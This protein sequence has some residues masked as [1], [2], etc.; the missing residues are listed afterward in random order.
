MRRAPYSSEFRAPDSV[1]QLTPDG[2]VGDADA[3]PTDVAGATAK[4]APVA[5]LGQS[6]PGGVP[7]TGGGAR[8]SS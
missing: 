1:G 5:T 3:G 4:P 6:P 2:Q 7:H 8:S